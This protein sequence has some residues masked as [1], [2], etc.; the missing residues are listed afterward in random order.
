MHLLRLPL[1]RSEHSLDGFVQNS[2]ASLI[3]DLVLNI[4]APQTP[5]QNTFLST[6]GPLHGNLSV[7]G[8]HC[9][10]FPRRHAGWIQGGRR[11]VHETWLQQ[12]Q[13]C[14]GSLHVLDMCMNITFNLYPTAILDL[15]PYKNGWINLFR[16]VRILYNMFVEPPCGKLD[17]DVTWRLNYS[18]ALKQQSWLLQNSTSV[19][20][21][22][23]HS[24][25]RKRKRKLLWVLQY[26]V[27][28]KTLKFSQFSIEIEVNCTNISEWH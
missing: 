27:N 25:Y 7:R 5:Q 20:T 6:G 1:S 13:G 19:C 23:F 11:L 15:F 4:S 18:S 17:I 26:N 8:A 2:F 24:N 3:L 28:L 21:N 14:Q 22:D 12:T 10:L 9:P 16:K